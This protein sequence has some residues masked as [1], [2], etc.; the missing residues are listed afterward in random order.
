MHKG[1]GY[2]R[3]EQIQEGVS[4][5]LWEEGLPSCVQSKLECLQGCS[6]HNLLWQYGTTRTLNGSGRGVT[7]LQTSPRVFEHFLVPGNL[8][9]ERGKMRVNKRF[10]QLEENTKGQ[11]SEGSL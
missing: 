11:G 9:R 6:V 8:G 7:L 10:A 5:D 2:D 4:G 1:G 3:V